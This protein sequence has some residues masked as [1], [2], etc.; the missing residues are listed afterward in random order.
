MRQ[1]A[2]PGLGGAL[3]WR[4]GRHLPLIDLCRRNRVFHNDRLVA[5][6]QESAAFL[7]HDLGPKGR[8]V[9]TVHRIHALEDAVVGL[10]HPLVRHLPRPILEQTLVF[11]V[12]VV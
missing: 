9:H 1:L 8:P 4:L 3:H 6:D 11:L 2:H 12:A 7:W 10:T 5:F